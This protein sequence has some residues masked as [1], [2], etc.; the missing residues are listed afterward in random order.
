MVSEQFTQTLFIH[1]QAY[2]K[3][4]AP[5][6]YAEIWNIWNL[7]IQNPSITASGRIFRTLSAKI[8]KLCVTQK[9]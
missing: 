8:G 2:S 4:C 9:I 3:A 5:L 6:T 7:D 1:V